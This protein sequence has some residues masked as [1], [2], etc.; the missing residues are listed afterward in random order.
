MA[1]VSTKNKCSY[2][3]IVRVLSLSQ[4]FLPK[5]AVSHSCSLWHITIFAHWESSNTHSP[6]DLILESNQNIRAAS[7]HFQLV[8]IQQV[9]ILIT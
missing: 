6:S 1:G 8:E 4:Q 9:F 7:S 2:K 3:S 5:I